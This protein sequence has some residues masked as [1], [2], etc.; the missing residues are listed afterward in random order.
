MLTTLASV[1]SSGVI[2]GNV[3]MHNTV[4]Q[5]FNRTFIGLLFGYFASDT[6]QAITAVGAELRCHLKYKVVSTGD[7]I[8]WTEPHDPEDENSFNRGHMFLGGWISR[9][10]AFGMVKPSEHVS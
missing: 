7:L 8:L 10:A 9:T 4:V 3:V 5:I 2:R 6:K 1:W